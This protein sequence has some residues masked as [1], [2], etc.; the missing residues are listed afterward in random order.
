M[1][2]KNNHIHKIITG[3]MLSFAVFATAQTPQG[4]R[5][6]VAVL[7]F[8]YSTVMSAVQAIFGTQANIGKGIS[9]LLVD[10][11]TND[12]VYRVIERNAI[13]KVT[14]E[15]NFSNSDRV[16]PTTA[17][18]IGH[19]LGVDAVITGSITTFGRD[20]QSHN[21]GG[22]AASIIGGKYGK[23]LGSIGSS[24]SKAVVA[25]TAR[26]IDVN[27]G[28]VLASATSRGESTRSSK[29]FNVGGEGVGSTS[30]GA[31][32][33][34]GGMQSSNFAQTIIGEATTASIAQ[35]AQQ[36]EAGSSKIET[37][38]PPAAAPIE[39]LVAD[40]SGSDIVINVSA[41]VGSKLLVTR[42]VRTV[43]D[44]AT[45]KVIHKVENNLGELTIT[46]SDASSSVGKFNGATP[47][48]VG[49]SVK[50]K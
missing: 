12:G 36:L 20:D 30:G 4:Q 22:G 34:N 24:K 8:D 33:A 9:D 28:E 40:V 38:A 45:G 19:I 18:K 1:F 50:S 26:M 13:D 23:A 44:P 3:F 6:R 49:D 14:N 17:A 25:V 16:D 7:D 21:Y 11:L 37:A 39:G 32:E 46:S 48:K 10:K 15:Q 43:K 42:V 5:H 2:M 41:P 29:N 27:T 35:L 47:P 31:A